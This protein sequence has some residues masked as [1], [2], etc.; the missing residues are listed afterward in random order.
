M[1]RVSLTILGLLAAVLLA[2]GCAAPAAPPPQNSQSP[3]SEAQPQSGGEQL[4]P[5]TDP[6]ELF[7]RLA[8]VPADGSYSVSY[9][10]HYD[11]A[12]A[13]S[14]YYPIV[15]ELSQM[16]EE[17]I[18]GLTFRNQ[19]GEPSL[20]AIYLTKDTGIYT[21]A[22]GF[23]QG[24]I[25]PESLAVLHER[26]TEYHPQ[27]YTEGRQ[28]T[29]AQRIKEVLYAVGPVL[30]SYS[31]GAQVPVSMALLLFGEG[32]ETG[33]EGYDAAALEK[34]YGP[35]YAQQVLPATAFEAGARD[36]FGPGV[37]VLHQDMPPAYRYDAA[38]RVYEVIP[39]GG[40]RTA[41]PYITRILR[42]E[43]NLVATAFYI[44]Y[45]GEYDSYSTYTDE[46]GTPLGELPN[47]LPLTQSQAIAADGK[48]GLTRREYVFTR[49]E[50]RL[51]LKAVNRATGYQGPLC[52][53]DQQ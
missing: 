18:G 52:V 28:D 4:P 38:L 17:T 49:H 14:F 5:T 8:Q 24:V 12:G 32:W 21:L 42:E 11:G 47:R 13:Y 34:K 25:T 7:R 31:E 16:A 2:A 35:G 40:M 1:K 19:A 50:G 39:T 27:Y 44:G 45:L 43:E 29:D 9:L 15:S 37:T 23:A 51:I 53:A 33:F 3:Q 26:M 30:D 10:G 36:I 46:E 22:D 48:H 20:L 41:T 6:E